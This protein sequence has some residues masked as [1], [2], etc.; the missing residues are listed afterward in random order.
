[1]T[2]NNKPVE[3]LTKK[4]LIT[5]IKEW[6]EYVNK[7]KEIQKDKNLINE[8]HAFARNNPSYLHNQT[9]ERINKINQ[10]Y[11]ELFISQDKT[12]NNPKGLSIIEQFKN[13]EEELENR[14]SEILKKA[15]NIL[16]VAT[17]VSLANSYTQG[18]EETSKNLCQLGIGF[19]LSLGLLTLYGI[20]VFESIEEVA[21]TTLI[22]KISIGFPLI[23]IA[24]FFQKIFSQKQR[25]KE[26]YHHKERIMMLYD[27]FE[28]HIKNNPDNK[29]N[30]V[31]LIK[32][33]LEAIAVNPAETFDKK[34]KKKDIKEL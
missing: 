11:S 28:K 10:N 4:E 34:Q 27:G 14:C 18:K 31:K 25:V 19:I 22:F 20:Y 17:T 16:K 32:T 6:G 7:V 9:I 3:Q 1:M 13:K 24:M 15:D 26:E 8:L 21:I 12:E 33:M 23:W 30:T 29:D 5:I 2:S